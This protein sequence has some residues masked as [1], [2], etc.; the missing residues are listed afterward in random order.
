[1]DKDQPRFDVETPEPPRLRAL[2]ILVTVLTATMILGFL[3]IIAMLVITLTRGPAATAL[4]GTISI[5][6]GETAQAFTQGSGWIAVVTRDGTGQ[7][8]IRI[9]S[10]QT[11]AEQQVIEVRTGSA[12]P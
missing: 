5:P 8:R 11:G 12:A 6:A 2:R 3:T 9:L 4:P 7:Q 1:M 10:A